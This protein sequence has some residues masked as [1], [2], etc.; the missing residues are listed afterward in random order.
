MVGRLEIQRL[1]RAAEA[2]L[3]DRFDVRDFHAVV[4]SEG[5]VPLSVLDELITEWIDRV[6]GRA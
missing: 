6:S 5:A 4:L 2:A 3:G 1:R